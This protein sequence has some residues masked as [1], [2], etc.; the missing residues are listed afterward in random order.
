VLKETE[1]LDTNVAESDGRER[2]DDAA[3]AMEMMV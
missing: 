2:K 3:L 1:M